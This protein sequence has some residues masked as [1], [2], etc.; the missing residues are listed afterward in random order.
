MIGQTTMCPNN[1]H[2]TTDEI[3]RIFLD[4]HNGH[5]SN[6]A[7]GLVRNGNSQ[8]NARPASKMIKLTYDC[9]AETSAF[10]WAQQCQD[11]DSNTRGVSE[12][13]YT[14]PN[15][16]LDM[17]VVARRVTSFNYLPIQRFN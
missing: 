12:N 11:R 2:I 13:R 9:A 5:R 17:T 16:N 14:F 10:A 3:R 8:T 15:K 1:A 6:L 7:R 4:L